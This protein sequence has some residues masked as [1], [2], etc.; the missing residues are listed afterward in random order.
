MGKV[1]LAGDLA[2]T[3]AAPTVAKVNGITVTG[4]P[5]TGQSIV[6]TSTSAA[7][8]QTVTGGVSDATTSTKG[9]VQLAG[10]LAGTAASPTV[11]GLTGKL[12]LSTATTKGDIFAATASATVSRLGVGTN[13]QVLTADSTQTTGVKWATPS[14]S[15]SSWNPTAKSA[16]YTASSNDF[17]IANASGAGFTVTLPTAASGAT[18]KVKKVDA[19]G[20]GVLVVPQSGTIDGSASDVVNSQW[21]SQDYLSDGTT[22][23]RV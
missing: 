11:P 18:V 8:W 2:G 16:N 4:T 1:Q 9:I 3:A 22:W 15:G 7:S 23:Y 12:S 13:G 14:A 20:N 5:T 17:V 10:D 19:T 21:Q 6:A